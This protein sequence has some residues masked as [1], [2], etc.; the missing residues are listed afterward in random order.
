MLERNFVT[1][2]FADKAA[3]YTTEVSCGF[4]DRWRSN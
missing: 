3:K 2:H 1:A 4:S